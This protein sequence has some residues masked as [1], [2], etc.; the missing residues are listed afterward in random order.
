ML[1]LEVCTLGQLSAVCPTP[2]PISGNY[3]SVLSHT[4]GG[5]PII[6]DNMGES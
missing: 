6:C 2:Q 4:K 5:N 1:Q 3:P